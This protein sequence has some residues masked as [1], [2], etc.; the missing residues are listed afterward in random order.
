MLLTAVLLGGNGVRLFHARSLNLE[1]CLNLTN[2]STKLQ[3]SF[4][5]VVRGLLCIYGM[6]YVGTL[7]LI[8]FR[9]QA[10]CFRLGTIVLSSDS[11]TFNRDAACI[12]SSRILILTSQSRPRQGL[13]TT[14]KIRQEECEEVS[15]RQFS[16]EFSRNFLPFLIPREIESARDLRTSQSSCWLPRRG[17]LMSN[18]EFSALRSNITRHREIFKNSKW[19][20]LTETY[21]S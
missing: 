19:A 12:G 16:S 15:C 13:S 14:K 7:Q 5:V 11:S 8:V 3:A 9:D 17:S 18:R 1:S 10:A 20:L 4:Y 21:L 2:G 6:G